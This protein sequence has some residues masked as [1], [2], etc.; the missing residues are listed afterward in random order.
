MNYK[1]SKKALRQTH[2]WIYSEKYSKKYQIGKRQVMMAYMDSSFIKFTYNHD[3]LALEINRCF[4]E[5][6]IPE[7]MTKEKTT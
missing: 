1:D 4:E 7:W 6:D 2:A 5:R 3:R